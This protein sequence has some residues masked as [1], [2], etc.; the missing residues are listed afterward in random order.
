MESSQLLDMLPQAAFLVRDGVITYV[1]PAAAGYLLETGT[2]VESLLHTGMQEYGELND[3]SL[4]LQLQLGTVL[5]EATVRRNSDGDLFLLDQPQEDPALQALALAAMK[6]RAPLS[7]AMNAAEQML[8]ALP[9]DPQG[10]RMQR[11]L[12]QLL[13]Y[14]GNMADAARYGG[15]PDGS[16]ELRDI[17]AVLDEIFEKITTVAQ[18]AGVTIQYRGLDKALVCPVDSERLERAVYNLISNAVKFSKPGAVIEASLQHRGQRLALT[19]R[20]AGE[21][22]PAALQGSLFHRYQRQPGF[23]DPRQGL[24]LGMVMIRA[25][26]AAHGGTV[27]TRTDDTGTQITLTFSLSVPSGQLR[28]P[29]FRVD[30]TG[31]RDHSLVELSDILP[32]EVYL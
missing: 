28:S 15:N 16:R 25:A 6:L 23:E 31:E 27:L 26:A 5:W 22:I 30:Y 29:A 13:R 10:A 1:N 17:C 9:E 21:G 7:G 19:V 12:H 32:P 4:C 14:V 18:Q 11:S 3:G 24:G 8:Q 2:P 20:D